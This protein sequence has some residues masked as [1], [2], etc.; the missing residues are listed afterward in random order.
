MARGAGETARASSPR[1]GAAA[2]EHFPRLDPPE[3]VETS[4]E[5]REKLELGVEEL[6]AMRA[7][8]RAEFAADSELAGH[9]NAAILSMRHAINRVDDLEEN[10]SLKAQARTI[11]HT[12]LRRYG[13][14]DGG[15]E[16]GGD[17][18]AALNGG[19]E[20]MILALQSYAS[21]DGVDGAEAE[22]ALDRVRE[23]LD[24][25]STREI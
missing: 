24:A 1:R 12:A 15:T 25:D 16:I 3:R 11:A 9:L 23:L 2:F 6:N 8:L 4:E 10:K 14:I 5:A 13:D 19:L 22:V 18:D 20:E 7:E 17:A 21:R